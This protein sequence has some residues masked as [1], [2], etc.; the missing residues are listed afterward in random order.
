MRSGKINE[1]ILRA[2][3]K[4]SE[5]EGIRD[6]LIEMIYRETENPEGHFKEQYIKSIDKFIKQGK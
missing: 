6:F 5:D 3:K 1:G 4:C 2:I